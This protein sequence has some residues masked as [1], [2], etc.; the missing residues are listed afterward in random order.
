MNILLAT[1]TAIV[2]DDDTPINIMDSGTY[3][4]GTN[5]WWLYLCTEDH[6]ALYPGSKIISKWNSD[7]SVLVTATDEDGNP[8]AWY[9]IDPDYENHIRPFGNLS[10]VATDSLDYHHW[11]GGGQRAVQ[12]V[13][14]VDTAAEYPSDNQPIVLTMERRL[15]DTPGFEGEGWI[16]T[17]EFTDPNR[18]PDARA[19]GIYTDPDHQDFLYTTGA[20]VWTDT[21][22]VDAEGNPIF[23]WETVNPAGRVTQD[24]EPIYYALLFGSA[25]EGRMTL[26]A[27]SSERTD[28]FWEFNQGN[29]GTG[30][31]EDSGATVTGM[32]GT[33]TLVSDTTPFTVGQEVR[34]EGVEMTVTSITAGQWLVLDPYRISTT[35]SVIQIR[36]S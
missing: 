13:P 25:Q 19:I 33:A 6:S 35:G 28:F 16:C 23:K 31:W 8:T 2:R 4:D 9:P 26:P 29:G 3:N 32:S 36:G 24:P 15:D 11:L 18:P 12:A 30:A 17:I 5:D 1:P 27:D 21:G 20:F 10:G 22:E 14:V 7:G 34:I